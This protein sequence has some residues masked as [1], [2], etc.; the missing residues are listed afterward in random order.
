MKCQDLGLAQEDRSRTLLSRCW[1]VTGFIRKAQ[2]SKRTL[3]T[4]LKCLHVH[5]SHCYQLTWWRR[6]SRTSTKFRKRTSSSLDSFPILSTCLQRTSTTAEWWRMILS[7]TRRMRIKTTCS[8]KLSHTLLQSLA[9]S[10]LL[11]L[12]LCRLSH[13]SWQP[14]SEDS[15]WSTSSHSSSTSTCWLINSETLSKQQRQ[16]TSPSA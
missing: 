1:L 5:L 16:P 11:G 7:R 14:T 6:L 12:K 2:G 3:R 13:S 15:T 4:L 8:M 10:T 9:L